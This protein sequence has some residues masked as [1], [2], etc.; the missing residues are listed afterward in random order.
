MYSYGGGLVPQANG[1]YAIESQLRLIRAF[2]AHLF[3]IFHIDAYKVPT[4][5][6]ESS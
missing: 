6:V 2:I 1:E 5:L 3:Y 4:S